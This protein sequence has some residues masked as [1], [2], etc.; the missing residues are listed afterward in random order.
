MNVCYGINFSLAR[1]IIM[2]YKINIY[3]T[4]EIFLHY[5][6]SVFVAEGRVLRCRV[7]VWAEHPHATQKVAHIFLRT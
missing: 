5:R 4:D 2:L 7:T 6:K 1:K 3:A